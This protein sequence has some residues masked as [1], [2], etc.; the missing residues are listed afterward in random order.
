MPAL[1]P[2]G[3]SIEYEC[4]RIVSDSKVAGIV[5]NGYPHT[6]LYT[7]KLDNAEQAYYATKTALWCYLLSSWS[8][9][10]L[11]VNPGLTGAEK[12]TAQ[13]VLEA[14]KWIYMR[15]MAWTSIPTPKLT[16]APDRDSAYPVTIDGKQYLQQVFTVT[17][18]TW[19]IGKTADIALDGNAPA[20]T[21]LVDANNRDI[22]KVSLESSGSDGYQ[23][24]VKVLYPAESI[25][26][27]DGTVQ[28]KLSAQADQFAIFY[29]ECATTKYGK[30]QDYMLDTD[31]H[32]PLEGDAISTYSKEPGDPPEPGD[33]GTPGDPPST[34][35]GIKIIKL[36]S[37]TNTPL[38]G[39]VFKVVNPE[40]GTVGSF[41]SKP[42]GTITIPLTLT[43]HYTVE[44]V[45]PPKWHLKSDVTT[46][47]VQVVHGKIAE[48]TF[49]NE[50][51]GNL[52]VEKYS[53]TGEPLSGDTIQIKHIAT[54]ETKSGQT[55]PGGAIE[56]TKLKP[57]GWEVRET[58]GIEG[59]IATTDT[60]QTVSIA[61]GQTSTATFINKELPGIKIIKY[62]R[63]TLKVMADIPFEIWRDGESLGQFQ[64]DQMGEI[65]ITN[66]KPGTYVVSE[67]MS[68][69][70]HVTDTTPQQVELH[71]G[72]GI[73]ELVF[74]NG[75]KPGIHL[76][77]VDAA[78]LSKP[79]PNV[80]FAIRAVDGSFG[81][82]EFT[83]GANVEIDLSRLS[84]GA[85]EVVEL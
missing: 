79:L 47:H 46:Q 81:P 1:V 21:R 80:K 58:A 25:E 71:A 38:E 3:T 27:Q 20:G 44:E 35:T 48:V 36:E 12:E 73:K 54:G 43:G 56:F 53:D 6:E 78:N 15:G 40:G 8:V 19:T 85:Y 61:T 74:F 51:F 16:A 10:K 41:S 30:V 75:R 83:T 59:W 68:D 49:Y 13:K 17:S 67:V 7:L 2:E 57:G 5:A 62:D 70:E 14:T 65:L 66:A 76:I 50:P 24:T 60:I 77:K 42:D 63:T 69:D 23:G 31:P 82:Q 45:N 29:A 84:P 64:T 32:I 4:D 37:G 18:N 33:P 39:A 55:G 28:L 34:G 9:D 22:T 26:G 11:G 52:R 72:D